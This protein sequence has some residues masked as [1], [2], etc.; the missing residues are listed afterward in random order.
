MRSPFRKYG[1]EPAA[2]ENRFRQ[3]LLYWCITAGAESAF[4]DS[5]QA[6]LY[7]ELWLR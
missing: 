1:R 4:L 3:A 7:I 5:S 6:R 2:V